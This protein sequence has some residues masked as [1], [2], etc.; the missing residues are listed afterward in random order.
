MSNLLDASRFDLPTVAL[1]GSVALDNAGVSRGQLLAKLRELIAKGRAEQ[2]EWRHRFDALYVEATQRHF[3]SPFLVQW[4]IALL[5]RG[6]AASERLYP[7]I[8]GMQQELTAHGET[9]DPESKDLFRAAIDLAVSW[10]TP[11]P[12]LCDKLLDLA[13][14]RR[15]D[16]AK[17][18][19]AHPV[20]GEV[21]YAELSREH[22]ARYPKIR[23]ALAK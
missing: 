23:A 17:V 4:A 3:S 11:Y 10:I 16:E 8:E 15:F 20:E 19:R 14:E 13:S 6:R 7:L 5:E 12:R 22:L 1:L 2:E 18:L 9:L 21:D